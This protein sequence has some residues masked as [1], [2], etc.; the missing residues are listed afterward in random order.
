MRRLLPVLAFALLAAT[1]DIGNPDQSADTVNQSEKD[2]SVVEVATWDSTGQGKTS[3]AEEVTAGVR[4]EDIVEPT[5]DYR[6]ASFG[7]SDP[8]LPPEKKADNSAV[9]SEVPI[10]SPLQRFGLSE[11]KLVGVW[12]LPTGERKAMIM[13]PK[14]E[15]IIIHAGDPIGKRS[16][17]I[18]SIHEEHI[19]AREFTVAPDGTRQFEDIPVTLGSGTAFALAEK[20]PISPEFV[21]SQH[22]SPP[23][24][25]GI[26]GMP[27][28]P[29][30]IIP[31]SQE[32]E[33]ES[34]SI[35]IPQAPIQPPQG[36]SVE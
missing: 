12:Q 35:P 26:P 18:L 32:S 11:L 30:G 2:A 16:G 27:D 5:T 19:V 4:V 7:K 23:S 28:A 17:K 22:Y 6:Y 14:E 20:N 1:P 9:V 8:F 3:A 31:T 15:G 34:Y 13:T 25:S 21:N 33:S 29:A 36:G 10:V 24:G